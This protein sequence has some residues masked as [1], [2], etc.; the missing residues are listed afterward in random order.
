MRLPLLI[1]TLLITGFVVNGQLPEP[2]A[3]AEGYYTLPLLSADSNRIRIQVPEEKQGFKWILLDEQGHGWPFSHGTA[4]GEEWLWVHAPAGRK[5][6]FL[7]G[8]FPSQFTVDTMPPPAAPERFNPI[9]FLA[10]HTPDPRPPLSGLQRP[11]RLLGIWFL[12]AVVSFT[13]LGKWYRDQIS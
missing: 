5:L 4:N 3:F 13:L 10:H 7:Y 8:Q 1:W 2:Y 6:R 11:L 12:I 9:E